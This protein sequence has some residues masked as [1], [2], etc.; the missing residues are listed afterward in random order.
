MLWYSLEAPQQD[1]SIGYPQYNFFS[2]RNKKNINK[3]QLKKCLILSCCRY[4]FYVDCI[5][6]S[7]LC[8]YMIRQVC[9]QAD[10]GEKQASA[11]DIM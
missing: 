9:K 1:A 2:S 11:N 4:S 3:F 5:W 8:H 7:C 6:F 10:A